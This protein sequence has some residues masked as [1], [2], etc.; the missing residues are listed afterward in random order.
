MASFLGLLL[1]LSIA[2]AARADSE[3]LCVS[4]EDYDSATQRIKSLETSL[5][6]SEKLAGELED[7]RS[8][9]VASSLEKDV[10]DQASVTLFQRVKKLEEKSLSLEA[11]VS[12][13]K[14]E[15][16]SCNAEVQRL[17]H[18]SAALS[19]CESKNEMT[20]QGLAQCISESESHRV[21]IAS[22]QQR[23][24][25]QEES[26][27]SELQSLISSM[28]KV[29]A[30]L[31][32]V[33][34]NLRKAEAN[35]QKAEAN[36]QKAEANLNKVE[37]NLQ[38]TEANLEKTQ[39]N[40]QRSESK[41]TSEK[42]AVEEKLAAAKKELLRT[43][44]HLE[45][46]SQDSFLFSFAQFKRTVA[47]ISAFNKAL[48]SFVVSKVEPILP[49]TLSEDANVYLTEA[50]IAGMNIY[51]TRVEPHVST[52]AV[53]TAPHL[54]AVRGLYAKHAAE[55]VNLARQTVVTKVS[56][57]LEDSKIQAEKYLRFVGDW[58]ETKVVQPFIASHPTVKELIPESSIDRFFAVAYLL[59]VMF[60][61]A[62]LVRFALYWFACPVLNFVKCVV[63]MPCRIMG[64]MFGCS[65]SAECAKKAT[66][67]KDAVTS[68]A[69][70]K[71]ESS[72][73]SKKETPKKPALKKV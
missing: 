22:G 50:K 67:K 19:S 32:K 64:C 51:R 12:S 69:K 21:E 17:S 37:A 26:C 33:E 14:L 11:D 41:F 55:P 16:D 54:A 29:E 43:K 35:L 4:Q 36:L 53:L 59:A 47:K 8:K 40:L 65:K 1:L 2:V 24:R 62:C 71:K 66:A 25:S 45:K 70:D 56:T 60:I 61:S 44:T 15:V 73:K 31:R 9:L 10:C 48:A 3:V 46:I 30:N 58:M 68:P 39:A 49:P 57:V 72:P 34:A 63:F 27:Q 7:V 13:K 23:L 6:S 28:Q 42:V 5:A 38:K 20:R 52:L 18:S